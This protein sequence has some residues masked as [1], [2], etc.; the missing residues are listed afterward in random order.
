MAAPQD[1]PDGA[2]TSANGGAH[3]TSVETLLERLPALAARI[4]SAKAKS[5]EARGEVGGLYSQAEEDGYHRRALREAIRLADMEPA[6]LRDYLIELNR[7]CEALQVFS[8]GE[9]FEAMP[10]PPAPPAA[11]AVPAE[12]GIATSLGLVD[13][14]A[15]AEAQLDKRRTGKLP[16]SQRPSLATTRRAQGRADALQGFNETKNPWPEGSRA[17]ASYHQGWVEGN[18]DLEATGRVA[19]HRAAAEAL[20]KKPKRRS[21]RPSAPGLDPGG[22]PDEPQLGV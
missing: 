4:G 19:D 18:A 2:P 5:D 13:P 11:A 22:K 6:K 21:R 17:Y 20:R 15:H 7:Y 9:L 16:G 14:L 3:G 10:R 1:G 8:Q 12:A